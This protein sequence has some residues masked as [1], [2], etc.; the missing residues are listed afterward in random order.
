MEL[1]PAQFKEWLV[2]LSEFTW[3]VILVIILIVCKDA[4]IH[5]LKAI[6]DLIFRRNGK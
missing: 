2:L 6:I 3:P 4:V 1:N 5:L